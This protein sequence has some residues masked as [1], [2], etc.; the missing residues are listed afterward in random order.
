MLN[1]IARIPGQRTMQG[2]TKLAPSL[3]IHRWRCLRGVLVAAL[4]LLLGYGPFLSGNYAQAR[5]HVQ[6]DECISALGAISGAQTYSGQWNGDCLSEKDAPDGAGGR[7]ARFYTF[8]LEQRSNIALE[9]T[10][11]GEAYIDESIAVPYLYLMEG[12]GKSGDVV[13]EDNDRTP[14]LTLNSAVAADL[15][16]GSYTIEAT[17]YG[18]S[19]SGSFTLSV[20]VEAPERGPESVKTTQGKSVPGNV[21]ETVDDDESEGGIYTWQDGDRTLRVR[22]TAETPGIWQ[23]ASS[24]STRDVGPQWQ[25]GEEAP[26][27]RS[28][29]GDNLM[30]LPGGVLLVLGSSWEQSDIDDFFAGNGIDPSLVSELDFLE[31]AFLV[32]TAPGF[33]SLELA[34]SLAAQEGVEISSPNWQSEIVTS[35][36]TG[37][38]EGDDHGDSTDTATDLPLNTAVHGVIGEEGDEDFFKIVIP[39]STLVEV[40]HPPYPTYSVA[41]GIVPSP[42]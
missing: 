34:N 6:T 2:F 8:T 41:W 36:G 27:F 22:L 18:A 3:R 19:K 1:Y 35:Q 37:V 39:E 25:R 42:C 10:N 40:R 4:V 21:E 29:T 11:T 20:E 17:T 38:E 15:E 16:A 23:S 30:T 12:H 5:G 14:Y 26:A 24:V 7:Y 31:N 13:A 33:P 28:E 9:L 32:E